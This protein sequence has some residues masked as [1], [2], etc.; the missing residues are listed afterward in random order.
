M[1]QVN[2]FSPSPRLIDVATRR[3][4]RHWGGCSTFP[5]ETHCSSGWSLG[6][7]IYTPQN[8][9]VPTL[10][11]DE[12]PYAA[13]LYGGAVF[14]MR[15]PRREGTNDISIDRVLELDVG[16]MGGPLALGRVIQTN[17]HNLLGI[18]PSTQGMDQS[19]AQR[20]GL[21]AEL[22]PPRGSRTRTARPL[23]HRLRRP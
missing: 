11:T 18:D 10:Q 23:E 2:R 14:E 20:A 8:I 7:N 4:Q 6:Q 3:L 17:W 22:Q 1:E 5:G 9:A 16:M 21:R 12:R 13:W 19:T 15:K